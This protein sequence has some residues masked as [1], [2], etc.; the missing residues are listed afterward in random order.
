[1]STPVARL[2]ARIAP[3]YDRANAILSLGL[4]NRW[5]RRMIDALDAAGPAPR[6][7][8]LCAGTL[9]CSRLVLERFPGARVT[10]VDLCQPML[11]AGLAKLPPPM[12]GRLRVV[13][14]DA[15]EVDLPP[16]SFDAVVCAWGMRNIADRAAILDGIRRWLVPGG[17]L[18][19]LE[20]FRPTRLP[21]RL[22]HATAGRI[23]L[24]AVG[25]L[26]SGDPEA[27]RYLVDSIQG[28]PTRAA[29]GELLGARGFGVVLARDFALGVVSL[30]VAEPSLPF[31][32]AR[33]R[34]AAL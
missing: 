26:L 27:Y 22:F 18:A 1:M 31:P 8:D 11:D 2:F 7:L 5:R 20:F 32:D 13:C 3:V 25:G 9:A 24:P 16:A 12:R 29:Y 15:L 30:V 4:V 14:A 17:K 10:A 28:F 34:P 23:L 21:A 6:V 19:V 33:A